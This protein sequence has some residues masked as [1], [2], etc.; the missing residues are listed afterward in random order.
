MGNRFFDSASEYI[1]RMFEYP[2]YWGELGDGNHHFWG[3]RGGHV[4]L[5]PTGKIYRH[6]N[7]ESKAPVLVHQF[8]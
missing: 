3:I 7:E 5:T 8:L 6:Y 2:S 1:E 4:V